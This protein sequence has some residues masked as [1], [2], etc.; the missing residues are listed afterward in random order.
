MDRLIP[1][2]IFISSHLFSSPT[3]TTIGIPAV[4]Y[5]R[6]QNP[7]QSTTGAAD[8]LS[9][10]CTIKRESQRDQGRAEDM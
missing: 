2:S 10:E 1:K 4:T 8:I 7:D 5:V 3:H 9:D 6:V